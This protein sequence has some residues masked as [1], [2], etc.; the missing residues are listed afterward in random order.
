MDED[1]NFIL[2]NISSLLAAREVKVKTGEI[3]GEWRVHENKINNTHGMPRNIE[4]T[5]VLENGPA[6]LRVSAKIHRHTARISNI[7]V[8]EI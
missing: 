4:F 8:D 7:E 2:A 5:V 1:E 6:C 3:S